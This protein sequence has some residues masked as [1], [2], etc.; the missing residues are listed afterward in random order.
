[1]EEKSWVIENDQIADETLKIANEFLNSKKLAGK[2]ANTL[3][4]YRFLLE[5]FLLH[6]PKS[7]GEFTPDDVLNWLGSQYGDKEARTMCWPGS[8]AST[9]L[10]SRRPS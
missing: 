1:M 3:K 10:R 4:K 2:S 8:A 6:C 5:K 9:G 7:L